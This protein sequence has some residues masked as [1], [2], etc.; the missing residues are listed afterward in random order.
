M[1]IFELG[2]FGEFIGS[3]AVV[4][5]LVY[6]AVQ[7]RQTRYSIQSSSLQNALG[8]MNQ[9]NFLV[10]GNGE[11]SEIA[12]TGWFDP[13][14]LN[15]AQFLRFGAYLTGIFHVFQHLYLDSQKGLVDEK[16]WLGEQQAML[17]ILATSGARKW[18]TEFPIPYTDDFRGY[19]DSIL[20][21]ATESE[22]WRK[23]RQRSP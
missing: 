8:Y 4:A 14:S 11:F 16:V 1:T 7:L 12:T 22:G 20:D 21:S 19:V 13:D 17:G 15:Q 23:F 10:A 9:A 5:T 2:A 3:I 6:L 18:W